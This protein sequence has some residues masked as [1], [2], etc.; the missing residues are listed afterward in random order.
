MRKIKRDNTVHQSLKYLLLQNQR[1]MKDNTTVSKYSI[2]ELVMKNK[3]KFK[4]IGID[5]SGYNLENEDG[6]RVFGVKEKHL[7]L[8]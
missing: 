3:E 7:K 4:V 2:G 1:R 5:K 6:E 8:G